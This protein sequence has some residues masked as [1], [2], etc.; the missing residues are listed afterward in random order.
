MFKVFSLTPNPISLMILHMI[1]WELL[2][3]MYKKPRDGV[4]GPA[5]P[6]FRAREGHHF[7]LSCTAPWSTELQKM[8]YF[9]TNTLEKTQTRH[10]VCKHE[11]RTFLHELKMDEFSLVWVVSL[12]ESK[13]RGGMRGE[14]WGGG[15]RKGKAEG[16]GA[17][18]SF[19]HT[20][21]GEPHPCSLC[22]T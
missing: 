11:P 21:A 8:A 18:S 12:V 19:L 14:G 9:C 22:L 1:N 4:W 17:P 3:W 5:Y 7:H 2:N 13:G 10:K 16:R 20:Q 6:D 15:R